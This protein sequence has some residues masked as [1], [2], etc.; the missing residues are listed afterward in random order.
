MVRQLGLNPHADR[1]PPTVRPQTSAAFELSAPF[2]K[3]L[4]EAGTP[5]SLSISSVLALP[6]YAA[7]VADGLDAA[8]ADATTN[9]S[10]S[11]DATYTHLARLL[12]SLLDRTPET[13][14]SLDDLHLLRSAGMAAVEGEL[15]QQM[16]ELVAAS[17][18]SGHP[19]EALSRNFVPGSAMSQGGN[20]PLIGPAPTAQVPT[21]AAPGSPS[22]ASGHVLGALPHPNKMQQSSR[23]AQTAATSTRAEQQGYFV[24]HSRPL[25]MSPRFLEPL[26]PAELGLAA[27]IAARRE[28]KNSNH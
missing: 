12:R 14:L 26:P 4:I 28:E 6:E 19:I 21:L 13:A 17:S 22:K 27:K 18:A 16:V 11:L 5:P 2:S 15:F 3:R 10:K 1:P 7:L 20:M 9:S 24:L 25:A 8:E 23:R